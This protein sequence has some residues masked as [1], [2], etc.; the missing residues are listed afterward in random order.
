M[1]AGRPAL[2]DR[3][4]RGVVSVRLNDQERALI[5]GAA[6]E[7]GL[8]VSAWLRMVGLEAVKRKKEGSQ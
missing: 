4:L 1:A 2:K 6:S 8:S 3:S 5:E 7:V